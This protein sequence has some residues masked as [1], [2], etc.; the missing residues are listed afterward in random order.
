LPVKI[1]PPP[2]LAAA[3]VSL[4]IATTVLSPVNAFAS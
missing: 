3:A 4:S 2:L 1:E